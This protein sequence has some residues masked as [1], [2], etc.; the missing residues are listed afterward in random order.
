MKANRSTKSY[1]QAIRVYKCDILL[2]VGK[3]CIIERYVNNDFNNSHM[4]TIGIDYFNKNIVYENKK[5]T[6]K[7]NFNI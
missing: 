3:T 2:D 5:Y 1:F 6:L 7:V 4:I